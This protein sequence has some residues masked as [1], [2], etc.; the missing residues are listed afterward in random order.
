MATVVAG[1]LLAALILATNGA[2]VSSHASSPH[3]AKRASSPI[4]FSHAVVVDQQRPGFEPDVKVDGN[5]N[6]YTSVP[7]GFSTTQSFVWSSRDKGN[8]YQLVPGNLGPGK[9][10]TCAGGGDTDLF[11][12]SSNALYFS[13]LQGLTNISN[14]MSTDGGATWSTNCA[15][16]P[17]T[18]DDRMW[19]AG[20]GSAAAGNLVL[21]QDYDATG[22]AANGGN[23][24]VETV[25]TD[26]THFQPVVN[27]NVSG[28][29]GDCAGAAVQDCVTNNEGISGNQVVD[30][31]TGNV[32]IAHTST[33]GS[34]G[35][36]GVRVSEGKITLG[37]PTT[38][39]WTE[40]PNLVAPLCH[41]P[42][43]VDTN[44]NAEELAGEN[45]ASIARDSAG[46]LYVTFTAGPIGHGASS[47]P[48]FNAL[49]APE[50]IY[51]VHSLSPAGADPSTLTWSA[52]QA[53][54]GTG[55]SAG[56]NTFPWITAG[57]D[58][59]VAVAWYHTGETTE[60][61]TCA[62]G[63]GT[64]TLYGASSFKN[65]EWTVQLGQSLDANS[66]TPSYATANVSE[67]PVK[68]G[69]ICTSG[70][71]CATGGDRSLGDYLQVAP[72]QQ[73]AAVVSYVFDT[74][75]DTSSGE[76]A[77]PEVI[78]RQVSGPS[79]FAS[80]GDVTQND[81]PG[82]AMGSV[83]DPSGDAN[84]SANGTRSPGG[85]NLDL[86][87]ASLANGA[88]RTLVAKINL[89]SLS[90]LAVAPTLGGPDASWLI[91]W[92]VVNPGSTGNGHIYYAGMDNN[93]GA[94][95][96]GTPTFFA[97][98]TTG[99]PANNP[100]E[101]TKYF[102][103]PQTHL[104]SS[105]QA[106]YD[107]NSGVITLNIPLSDVGNPAN[108]T[109]LYSATAFSATSTAP[110]SASTLFNLTDA[111]TPFELVIGAPGS[112]GPAVGGAGSGTGPSHGNG[113]CAKATGRLSSH[114]LGR[115]SLGTTRSRARHIYPRWSTR[116]RRYTDFYCVTPMGIRAGYPTPGML[117]HLPRKARRRQQGRIV[118]LLSANRRYA[119]H[120]V[121]PGT[122]LNKVARRL[123]VSRRIAIGRNDW[124]LAPNGFSHGVLKVRHGVILE[125]GVANRRQTRNLSAARQFLR[126]LRAP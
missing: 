70:L 88:S 107:K 28:L 24:L 82:Q 116:G 126:N 84:Y 5:G 6:V 19:F 102:A 95:G 30:P 110:Q 23:Q 60:P 41:D 83:T 18:P 52:P 85:P 64:C 68:H 49:T 91:R 1:V 73:G 37:T 120:G 89:K 17:N 9:P 53:I 69:Q 34:G 122:R 117:R 35:T 105:S 75:N 99:I 114:G 65:A 29:T 36:P 33:E 101:H 87:G 13:D 112:V 45:F 21:Y 14:S 94:G 55:A 16:A 80:A 4:G 2:T 113:R 111:T 10:A 15:G 61:G 20:T 22:T 58:G 118:L 100:G 121:R 48:N 96:A 44:S 3:A 50:Q 25:S 86:L 31:S 103:Y 124:Y 32:F 76:D 106:S 78:S 56:T 51:V 119:L 26:G 43:C 7:F 92:T 125:V 72:D 62:S 115:L 90:S 59:R 81:G 38:A 63:T 40:S 57:S 46:Y 109:R 104:L 66:A 123:H 12:D 27:T 79:L 71:G 93:Q 67:A 39:K 8:S 42:N 11:L 98:D 108:G 47:D 97:G 77:G 54:T 74:S